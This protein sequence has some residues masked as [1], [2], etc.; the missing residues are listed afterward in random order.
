MYTDNRLL[1]GFTIEPSPN[2]NMSIGEIDRGFGLIEL[3]SPIPNL[4]A[5]TSLAEMV[6]KLINFYSR[7]NLKEEFI[8]QITENLKSVP[9][10]FENKS[11]KLPTFFNNT[12]DINEIDMSNIP[13]D[14][15]T[16]KHHK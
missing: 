4:R 1:E 10:Y 3:S 13:E 16:I 5:N 14:F 9:I 6:E 11:E 2:A 8:K 15:N 12:V 7:I